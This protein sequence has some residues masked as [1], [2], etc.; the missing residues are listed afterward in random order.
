VFRFEEGCRL[1]DGKE[2]QYPSTASDFAF[3]KVSSSM[4]QERTSKIQQYMQECSVD[5]DLL[6]QNNL[7]NESSFIKFARDRGLSVSGVNSGDP[8]DF[9]ERGWLTAD[10]MDSKGRPLFHPFRF[11]TVHKILEACELRIAPSASLRR[12]RIVET[13]QQALSLVRPVE[14]TIG[15]AIVNSG[16]AVD[17]AV[18]L[19]PVYWRRLTNRVTYRN[20][21]VNEADYEAR[22]EQYRAKVHHVVK[23]LDPSFWREI[24]RLMRVDASRLDDNNR[25]YV[26]LRLADWKQREILKGAIS[27]ALWIRHIAEIIRRAFE[28]IHNQDW[29]EEDEASVTWAVGGRKLVFGSARPLDNEAESKP[30]VASEFGLYTGSAVRWYVE[31]VTEY[32]AVIEI[33]NDPS[34]FGIEIVNLRGNISAERDNAALKLD[35]WLVE[36]KTQRRF[37]IISFDKDVAANLKVIRRQV[38]KGNVVG[39]IAP[40]QP[41]FEFA[42]FAL[43]ELVEIAAG[44]DET[45]G[46][47]GDAVREADWTSITNAHE[48][49]SRYKQVS[50]RQPPSLKGEKWGRALAKYATKHPNRSD[51]NVQRI[52]WTEIE[53]AIRGRFANYE[54]EM[55]NWEFDPVT[56]QPVARKG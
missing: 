25:L 30:Y 5:L 2:S 35:E 10:R 47:S 23:T 45:Y 56:F 9:H 31:G 33:I 12:D 18:I 46:V 13:V 29:L 48:F 42:N 32:Y 40:H 50:S 38:I 27:G 37:S 26:L 17:L 8:G 51:D 1:K 49:E 28:E 39:F 54:V 7:L 21:H 3:A 6:R 15:D 19:E 16:A 4:N 22:L 53:K 24:H 43:Q 34:Q 20:G 41:D 44:I 55:E 52:F 36:D 11:Y 14:E